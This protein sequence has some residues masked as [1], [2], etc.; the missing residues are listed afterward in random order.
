MVAASFAVYFW[1][2][3]PP[4]LSI[5][6][7]A[8]LPFKPLVAE[9]RD[10]ALEIGMAETLIA[11]LGNNQEIV[12][13]PLSSVRRYGNL[14]QDALIAGRALGVDSVLDGNI[15]RWGDN[16]R[17]NVSLVRVSDGT[18]LWNGTFDENSRTFS[19]FRI[20]SRKE[21]QPL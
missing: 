9:N 1:R 17:I 18:L 19:Q 13:R 6:S 10:E 8:V 11:R 20:Q 15:Q 4:K 2:R 12:V 5:K 3:T 21:W 16:I 14:E 7:V